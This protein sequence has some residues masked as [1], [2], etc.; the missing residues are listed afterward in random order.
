MS[1]TTP[2]PM[3]APQTEAP[4]AQA[5]YMRQLLAQQGNT[6][7]MTQMAPA[8]Q[9]QAPAQ[10]QRQQPGA[11]TTGVYGAGQRG[12][13]Q[14]ES[15]QN[16]VKAS[17]GLANQFAQYAEQKQQRQYQQVIGRF[18]AATQG[19]GQAQAQVLQATQ[20]L[21]QN[22]QDPQA[23]QQ[24]KTAQDAL[25]QNQTILNDMA[26]DS[27]A[28]KVI[29]KAFGI[30]D[31]NAGSPERQA[32]ME[33][34]KKQGQ[35]PALAGISAQI[36]QTQQLSPQAQAQSQMQQAGVIGKPATQGQLMNAEN[37]ANR[38]A[39]ISKHDDAAD[40]LKAEAVTSKIG[41][42]TDKMIASLPSKGMVAL[43]NDDGTPKR[44]SDGTL[45]TRNITKDEL[46]DPNNK[47]Y[48]PVLAEKWSENNAKIGLQAQQA[49]AV[50]INA[51]AHAMQ[52]QA[53][54]ATAQLARDP[55]VVDAWVKAV[56]DPNSNA[57]I[58]QIPAAARGAVISKIAGSGLKLTKPLT[59]DELKR[60]D[61]AGNA[62]DNITKAQEILA[63]RPD[64]FG[65]G[66]WGKTK[67]EMAI[68]GGDKDAIDYLTDIK[69]ANLPAVGIHGVRGKYALEDLDK[70]D[71]N[72]YLNPESMG[73]VLTDIRRSATEFKGSGGRQSASGSEGG[74]PADSA[75]PMGILK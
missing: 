39:V 55:R 72:L 40:T 44:N 63:R 24:L 13:H 37:T 5:E 43:K 75:D 22:P 59:T 42:D 69:L 11:Q 25:K 27:K 17:T 26:N 15:M 32:A 9:P 31:K 21:K 16:L 19:V 29:T 62:V 12:A 4:Q 66:G 3:P 45:E 65:P 50:M 70:L 36:P 52:A 54:Q 49:K 23:Q 68:A 34:L 56:T 30:D 6:S 18:T 57:T 48:N 71:G 58:A 8:M 61:L 2:I 51:N 38:T 73:S 28:H 53:A 47:N 33:V 41:L 1:T 67:F 10:T 14:R 20:A 74:P 60:S 46:S 64:M 7:G 35:S